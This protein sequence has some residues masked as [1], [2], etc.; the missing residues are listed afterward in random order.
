MIDEAKHRR[1]RTASS[2]LDLDAV[3]AAKR[4]KEM[5]QEKR[6]ELRELVDWV[7]DYEDHDLSP[8]AGK[9]E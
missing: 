3:Q 8:A 1:L 9:E 6:D 2:L 7:H 5:T 4:L